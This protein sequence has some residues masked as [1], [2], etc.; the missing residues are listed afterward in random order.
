VWRE[1]QAALA[2]IRN[3]MVAYLD[4][5]FEDA[6]DEFAGAL[7]TIF[8]PSAIRHLIP[9]RIIRRFFIV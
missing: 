9:P 4:E 3:K 5:A 8:P 1:N 6:A 2:A 7:K